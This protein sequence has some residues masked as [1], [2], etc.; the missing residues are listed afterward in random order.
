MA[1]PIEGVIIQYLNE[2]LEDQQLTIQAYA[3]EPIN[4]NPATSPKSFLVVEKTGSSRYNHL[5]TSMIA[6]QSYAP[7]V[8]EASKLNEKVIEIMDDILELDRITKV[9]LNSAYVFMKTSTKQPRYQAV[10]DITH[11]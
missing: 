6:I 1:E 4:Q 10:F 11:Y 7:S 9:S 3:Q 5:Y 2:W 8:Y